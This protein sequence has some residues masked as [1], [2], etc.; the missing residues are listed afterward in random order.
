[1]PPGAHFAPYAVVVGEG[2]RQT[3]GG[4]VHGRAT[5]TDSALDAIRV[6]APR[7]LRSRCSF[8]VRLPGEPA[9]AIPVVP[10]P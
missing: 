7:A 8:T 6:D 2:G 3:L 1:M 5:N 4:G 10:S 9:R